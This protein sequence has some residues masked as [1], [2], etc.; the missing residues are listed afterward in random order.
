MPDALKLT[1]VATDKGFKRRI[2][3]FLSNKTLSVLEDTS[4]DATDLALAKLLTVGIE[5]YVASFSLM[6]VTIDAA[7]NALEAAGYDHTQVADSAIE[8]VVN[9]MFSSFA[10]GVS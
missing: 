6:I 1:E 4:P 8:S 7:A 3:Y 2:A 9:S 10:K 5:A